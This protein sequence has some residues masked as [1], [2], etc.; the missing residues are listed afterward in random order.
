MLL[1]LLQECVGGPEEARLGL[2]VARC[3]EVTLQVALTQPRAL[4]A[5][6]RVP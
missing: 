5:E 2:V 4:L 6:E 1:A 3:T